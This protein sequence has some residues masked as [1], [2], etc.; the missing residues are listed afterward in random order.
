M[1]IKDAFTF[2]N[3]IRIFKFLN[4]VDDR[5]GELSPPKILSWGLSIGICVVLFQINDANID[6]AVFAGA[7]M[8][9][10]TAFGVAYKL[11]QGKK[12][13]LAIEDD[14]E[15]EELEALPYEA[16]APSEEVKP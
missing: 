11:G 13:K 10:I 7:L 9:L 4:V 15:D 8:T 6:L 1:S 3:I 5:T 2:K 12:V 16:K 14:S